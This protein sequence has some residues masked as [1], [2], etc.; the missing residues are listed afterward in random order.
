MKMLF[1]LFGIFLALNSAFANHRPCNCYTLPGSN[2]VHNTCTDTFNDC[3]NSQQTLSGI[4][5][6]GPLVTAPQCDPSIVPPGGTSIGI[7]TNEWTIENWVQNPGACPTTFGPPPSPCGHDCG[8]M[9]QATSHF[10]FD[11]DSGGFAQNLYVCEVG[12]KAHTCTNGCNNSDDYLNVY[13]GTTLVQKIS[14]P[15]SYTFTAA[16]AVTSADVFLNSTNFGAGWYV[17]YCYDVTRGV[18][19][20]ATGD[21]YAA[22]D[23]VMLLITNANNGYIDASNLEWQM[24]YKCTDDTGTSV[25]GSADDGNAL[26]WD[27]FDNSVNGGEQSSVTSHVC[28]AGTAGCH[29]KSC[30][31]DVEFQEKNT[32][33]RTLKDSTCANPNDPNCFWSANFGTSLKV[34]T[35]LC[36]NQ[37]CG[38]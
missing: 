13:S 14:S 1:F 3:G 21:I 12:F 7:A 11:V 36:T 32:C 5:G 29:T 2:Q 9:D 27:E 31:Y 15:L 26:G 30:H 6:P 28:L 18:V 25:G 33:V 37:S 23:A 22:I 17:R 34:N 4:F 38:G 16:Q 35:H 20:T 19:G 24:E 10:G 8:T